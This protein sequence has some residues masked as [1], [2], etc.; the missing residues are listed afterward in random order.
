M[1]KRRLR[2]IGVPIQQD[3][4]Y[5]WKYVDNG[6]PLTEGLFRS[7]VINF[8][9]ACRLLEE[10]DE[11]FCFIE[12]KSAPVPWEQYRTLGHRI[13]AF[14]NDHTVSEPKPE[15]YFTDIVD[16]IA[17]SDDADLDGVVSRAI[18]SITAGLR[19]RRAG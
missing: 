8:E 6:W 19:R 15:V 4:D 3:K 11:R 18:G 1:S 10:V 9:E 16:R 17:E 12:K 7:T 5:Q 14:L 2:A 13:G